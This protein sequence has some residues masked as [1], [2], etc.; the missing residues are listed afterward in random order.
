MTKEQKEEYLS[1]AQAEL[2]SK[3]QAIAQEV[4]RV[5]REVMKLKELYDGSKTDQLTFETMRAI[6]QRR[7]RD[8]Q[9]LYP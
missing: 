2:A 7:F 6:Y 3:R 9:A 1:A 5:P 8:L 4:E